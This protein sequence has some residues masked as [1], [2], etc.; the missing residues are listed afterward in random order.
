M[1]QNASKSFK[2]DLRVEKAQQSSIL[3]KYAQEILSFFNLTHLCTNF[4]LVIFSDRV[5]N[6]KVSYF[7]V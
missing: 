2:I 5:K 3:S 4:V 7:K 6:C 1:I